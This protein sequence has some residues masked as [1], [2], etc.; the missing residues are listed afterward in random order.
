MTPERLG[1]CV[2][3]GLGVI[4][5]LYWASNST[6]DHV[7]VPEVQGQMQFL[8]LNVNGALA[9]NATGTPLDLSLATHFYAPGVNP[10]D[11]MDTNKV[12]PT[13]HRY[14]LVPGGNISSVMHQGW[15]GFAQNCPP[16]HDWFLN[17]PEAAVL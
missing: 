9:S 10:R 5:A 15:G 16:G 17:P 14:P 8:G 3:L 7:V 4:G 11:G 2:L 6:T 12:R 13:P 1:V